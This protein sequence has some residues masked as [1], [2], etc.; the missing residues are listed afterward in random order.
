MSCDESHCIFV[1]RDQSPAAGSS[2]CLAI[3]RFF[4]ISIFSRYTLSLFVTCWRRHN[5]R[6]S[7]NDYLVAIVACCLLLGTGAVFPAALC[8]RHHNN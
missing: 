1:M 6:Q 2:Y 7:R 3:K 8:E 5:S 4:V